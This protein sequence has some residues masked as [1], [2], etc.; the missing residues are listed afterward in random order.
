MSPSPILQK[1]NNRALFH[2]IWPVM[3][4]QFLAVTM[5]AADTAMVSSIGEF[6]VSGV[7]VVDNINQ[8]LTI[9]LIAL[10]TGGAVVV[11]QYI[12][13]QDNANASLAAKQLIYMV[14]FISLIITFIAVAFR[15]AILNFIYGN[16]ADDVMRAAMIYFLITALSYPMLGLFNSCAALFRAAGNSKVP[17]RVSLVTNIIHIAIN[18]LFIFVFRW[19][20][21]SVAM[22]T[23][24]SRI[25]A[26]GALLFLLMKEKRY[27]VSISGILDVRVIPS[28]AKRILNI[29]VPTGLEQSL[30]QIGRLLAQRIFP[31]FGTSVI[32][33]N[34][35][36]SVVSSFA[37]QTGNAIGIAALTVIGQCI[38]A[39]D[40][41]AAKKLT[42]KFIK[43]SYIVMFVISGSIFLFKN[44]L[45]NFFS[46]GPE[47][48]ATALLFLSTYCI[49]SVTTWTTS[50]FFPYVLR[51]AGDAKFIMLVGVSSMWTV[52]VFCA[53]LFSFNLGMGPVGVWFAMGLDFIV[54]S[55]FF[56]LR[57]RSGKWQK[58]KVITD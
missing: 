46:L 2:L 4:E 47:A 44:G 42:A 9:A 39:G 48:R 55:I 49:F 14:F 8:F 22:S 23:L 25:L 50:F 53:Y 41:D 6:A 35:V 27:P 34:A 15:S 29:G 45:L 43:L 31:R 18:A 3:L 20:V 37:W 32:A 5:G 30:F 13:R 11:S 56:T 10:S 38:G 16:L 17:M 57:W 7:N 40:Y 51:A 52:R 54:R 28:M 19:G 33:A 26:A 21:A 36:A 12:G 24:L 58:K 1:W